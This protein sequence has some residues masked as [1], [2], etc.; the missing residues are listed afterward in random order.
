MDRLLKTLLA[1][2]VAGIILFVVASIVYNYIG[3]I[4]D[5]SLSHIFREKISMKWFYKLLIIT[6][7]TGIIMA[8]LYSLIYSGL[9]GG[10]VFK[11]IFWGFVVW[12][13][14]VHQPLITLLVVGKFT[15]DMLLSWVVQGL[16]SYVAAGVSISL[17]YKD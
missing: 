9:P 11:G 10:N 6:A 15:M 14:I 8:F 7:G 1:G 17:I 5:P 16:V 2:V 3:H 4:S 13:I 12:L